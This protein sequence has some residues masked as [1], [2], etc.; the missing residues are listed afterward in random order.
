VPKTAK[1]TKTSKVKT[2]ASAK[3]RSLH[4]KSNLKSMFVKLAL[5]TIVLV[6]AALLFWKN[7][8]LFVVAVVNNQP[9]LRVSLERK[10]VTH[11]GDQTLDEMVGEVLIRQA[12]S[13]NN[14]K[15]SRAE[16][17]AKLSEIEKT[18]NGKITLKD[19]LAQQG[20]TL[21][22]FRGRIELQLILERLTASQTLVSDQEVTDYLASNKTSLVAT[23]EAGMREEAKKT[24]L[25]EKQ[26]TVLRQYFMDLKAKAQVIKFL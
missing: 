26:N 4:Q 21:E 2:V 15:V 1:K 20:D 10:L 14:I 25:S 3:S 19:A 17:D 13:K 9:I 22:G 16:I 11:F 23:D 7:K 24:L 12:A 6:A 18:L 5:I 8:G